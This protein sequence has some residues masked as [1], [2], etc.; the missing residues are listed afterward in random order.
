MLEKR[1]EGKGTAYVKIKI[2]NQDES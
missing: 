1:L 2:Y